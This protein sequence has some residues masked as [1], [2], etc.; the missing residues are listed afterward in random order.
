M[1]RIVLDTNVIVSALLSPKGNPAKILEL[2]TTNPQLGICYNDTILTEYQ[3]VLSR[4]KFKITKLTQFRVVNAIRC[5][6][7]F[8]TALPSVTPFSDESD[9][10][11][12]DVAK[13]GKAIL[14]TGN[15]KHYP[16]GS[17]IMTPA[18]FLNILGCED[19]MRKL[20]RS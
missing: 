7:I 6:G 20:W 1:T 10:V 15:T 4:E 2:L 19:I 14:V 16:D 18:D 5:M 8:V 17:I 12:Y 11:F 3:D 9:C 13:T